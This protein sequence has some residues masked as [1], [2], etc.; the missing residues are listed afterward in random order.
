MKL[1]PQ[2]LS[3]LGRWAV[4][5]LLCISATALVWQTPF[6]S[7][8]AANAAPNMQMIATKD[9][10][11]QIKKDNKSLVQDAADKVKEAANTNADRVDQATDGKGGFFNRKAQ[12]D[13]ARIE[14]RAN[15]DAART[16]KAI[17]R[18]VNAAERVVDDIK[19]TFK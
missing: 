18:N 15:E 2:L 4:A 11:D 16:Q 13:V 6:F 5:T 9:V 12:R 14:K 8:S 1:I 17:D 3:G 10:G 7:N 19:D